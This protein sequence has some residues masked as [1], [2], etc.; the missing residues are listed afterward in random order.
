MLTKRNVMDKVELASVY[1]QTG[2]FLEAFKLLDPLNRKLLLD[3]SSFKKY[4]YEYFRC[5]SM[6]LMYLACE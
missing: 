4:V 2:Q 5:Y 1:N 3:V 6:T